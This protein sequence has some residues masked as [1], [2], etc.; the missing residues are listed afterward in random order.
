[1]GRINF[2]AANNNTPST[3]I[4]TGVLINPSNTNWVCTLLNSA[5]EVVFDAFG[6]DKVSRY[7]PIEDSWAGIKLSVATSLTRVII[8]VR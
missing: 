7:Y 5:G 2:T 6:S 3:R 1:M 4:V 8:Y